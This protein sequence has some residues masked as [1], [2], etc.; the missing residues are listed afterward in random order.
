[1]DDSGVHLFQETPI[2]LNIDMSSGSRFRE[3]NIRKLRRNSCDKSFR[4]PVH[5]LDHN[6]HYK[7]VAVIEIRPLLAH[8]QARH[9]AA[10]AQFR[11]TCA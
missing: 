3:E 1:M 8:S 7:N 6:L 10:H 11:V 5:Y 4:K 9:G 2:L